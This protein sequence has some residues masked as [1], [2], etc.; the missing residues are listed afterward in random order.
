[1]RALASAQCCPPHLALKHFC[2]QMQHTLASCGKQCGREDASS[3][4]HRDAAGTARREPTTKSAFALRFT[5][6]STS[7]FTHLPSAVPGGPF[8]DS[9][10][11]RLGERR[12]LELAALHGLLLGVSGGLLGVLRRLPPLAGLLLLR[13][14]DGARVEVL[15][16]VW[17]KRQSR[18]SMNS[19]IV[20][21]QA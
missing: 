13:R 8:E 14:V 11:G 7:R 20:M 3:Q 17:V 19:S 15:R 4:R 2:T 16:S 18:V 1:M 12:W 21:R 9:D 6:S 5:C 10:R